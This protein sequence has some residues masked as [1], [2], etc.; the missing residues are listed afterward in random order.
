MYA[1]PRRGSRASSGSSCSST[2]T[3]RALRAGDQAVHARLGGA[4]R[5]H[6]DRRRSSRRST[7]HGFDVAFGG[8]RRDEEQL[9][10]EGAGLLVPLGAAPLGPEE[11]AARAV[12]P[13]QRA[14]AAR[15]SRSACSRC[16]T[17]PSS[18]SGNTSIASSIPVVPLY[19][20][21]ERPVV[22]RDGTL[23]MVDD[24]R[25]P[26]EP[27]EQPQMRRVRFRTLGCYPLTG[28][29]R[30]RRGHARGDHR[31][32]AA[33]PARP[34]AQGRMIDHDEPARW[35]R[36]SRRGTSDDVAAPVARRLAIALER[37]ELLRFITCGS[38]DDGK[39]TLIGRLLYESELLFE[40]QLAAL[41]ADSRGSARR[42]ARSTSRC[43]STGLRPSASRASRSTSRTG[44]SRRAGASSS[45]P[46]R[47]ATSST[48][49]TWSRAPRPPT[50]R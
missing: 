2:S 26:L 16:R 19:F 34:S 29:D 32:D 8:A 33:S 7:S 40:D 45:S 28:R 21:A 18:T 39:S 15:A 24:D 10:G 20:A 38:V 41:E 43:C 50:R 23:I 22:E 42:T 46:T 14:Q 11:P 36:R 17:G 13:L 47:P 31:G 1:V 6:E 30:E 37:E 3:R 27:G 4:H 5:R 48:R 49:A 9:A 35:S 12:E 44:S 25:M